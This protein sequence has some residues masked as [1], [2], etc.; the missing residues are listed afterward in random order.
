MSLQILCQGYT[1]ANHE[2]PILIKLKVLFMRKV[3]KTRTKRFKNR[4]EAQEWVHEQQDN[5]NKVYFEGGTKGLM[6]Y[7]GVK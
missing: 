2:K 7:M 1:V 6:D 5:V 3:L 4:T